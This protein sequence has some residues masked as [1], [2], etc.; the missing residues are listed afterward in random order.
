MSKR[1]PKRDYVVTLAG[2]LAF[3]LAALVLI[4]TPILVSGAEMVAVEYQKDYFV[5]SG[6]QKIYEFRIYPRDNESVLFS[7]SYP[8][9][10]AFYFLISECRSFTSPLADFTLC[11]S[12]INDN[13]VVFELEQSRGDVKIA[14]PSLDMV[15]ASVPTDKTENLTE[16]I[17]AL[18]GS[19]ADL[20]SK[21]ILLNDTITA[22]ASVIDNMSYSGNASI[23]LTP[24]SSRLDSLEARVSKLEKGAGGITKSDLDRLESKIEVQQEMLNKLAEEVA[25]LKKSRGSSS[26]KAIIDQFGSRDPKMAMLLIAIDNSIP[27]E[28]KSQLMAQLMIKQKEREQAFWTTVWISV[29]V[30]LLLLVAVIIIYARRYGHGF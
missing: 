25:K 20:Q 19:I 6:G 1:M 16:R 12:E 9:Q 15:V 7:M 18:E 8:S 17:E 21:I 10:N 5:V 23:D 22:Y 3:A 13:Y 24:L 27:E 4:F 11:L 26:L 30:G 2:G 14:D 29:A 28:Q